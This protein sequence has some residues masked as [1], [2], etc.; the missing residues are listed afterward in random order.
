MLKD[1][2]V[3]PPPPPKNKGGRPKLSEAEKKKRAEERAKARKESAEKK[4]QTV[5]ARAEARRRNKFD[6]AVAD[7]P[8]QAS[9]AAELQWIR[10][11]PAMSKVDRGEDPKTIIIDY[12]DV[13]NCSHGV[14]PSKAA[15]YQL[16]HYVKRPK[17]FFDKV[18]THQKGAAA[19]MTEEDDFSMTSD[20]APEVV[21]V[22]KLLMGLS[23]AVNEIDQ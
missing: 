18:L 12:D 22:K 1:P 17:D 15:V 5:T 13:M 4:K 3:P 14:A 19:K 23:H 6:K 8:D 10:N 2:I 16:Q 11:H 21:E 9:P 20:Q 7:L